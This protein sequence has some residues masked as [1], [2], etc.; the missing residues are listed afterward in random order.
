MDSIPLLCLRLSVCLFVAPSLTLAQDLCFSFVFSL[1]DVFSRHASDVDA[2]N[3]QSLAAV[4]TS[5]EM[6]LWEGSLDSAS[7]KLT[8]ALEEEERGRLELLEAVELR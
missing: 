7:V 3:A 6:L 1:A 5:D 8:F 4:S 2:V